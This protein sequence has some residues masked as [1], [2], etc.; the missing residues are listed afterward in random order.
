MEKIT[1]IFEKTI[2]Y[3]MALSLAVMFLAVFVNVLL[4]YLFGSG[5]P[6][7][8]ELS[9]L[10]FVWLIFLGATLAV[11]KNAHIGFDLVQS[12]LPKNL[13]SVCFI[14]SRILM[15]Y[16]LYLFLL[17]SWSQYQIGWN[18][19]S[20]VIKYPLAYM[21]ATGLFASIGMSFYLLRDL[22]KELN[23]I[24]N[25]LVPNKYNQVSKECKESN[26]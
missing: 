25:R 18:I 16:G 8:E 14:T 26:L 20:T 1:K 10:L 11:G 12:K 3:L 24:R 6:E 4:R 5:F 21:Y 15:L 9:R 23:I 17:G 13:R 2:E 19:T 7:S 22:I